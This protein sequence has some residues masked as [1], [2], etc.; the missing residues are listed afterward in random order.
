MLRTG[1]SAEYLGHIEGRNTMGLTAFLI[2]CYQN[3]VECMKLLADAGCNTAAIDN[4]GTNALMRAAC[5][6]AAAAVRTVLDA[7]WCE[8]EAK[9]TDGRTAFLTACCKGNVECM[10]LLAEA[11]CNTAAI[12]IIGNAAA[13]IARGRDNTA[14]VYWLRELKTKQQAAALQ[15]QA[16]DYMSHGRLPEAK[17]A[18]EKALRLMPENYELARLSDVVQSALIQEIEVK[19]HRA[20]VAEAELMAMLDGKSAPMTTEQAQKAQR[21]KEKRRRQKQAK[22][23]AAALNLQAIPKPEQENATE[24]VPEPEPE[25]DHQSVSPARAL[26]SQCS[27]I[28]EDD[29]DLGKGSSETRILPD[30]FCCPITS[31]C[32]RDPVLVT[33]TGMTYEREAITQWLSDHDI[34]PSTGTEL[35]GN[36]VLAPNVILRKLIDAWSRGCCTISL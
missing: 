28:V 14:A 26:T 35:N 12:D 1:S 11:G 30:E 31:E 16:Q 33:A 36:K 4:N 7:G 24:Q 22:R 20:R 27:E 9:N 34:D 13:D 19:E 2:A 15:R 23:E 29:S 17:T 21:K 3:H 8:L 10:K 6:G 18:A 5:S 25:L 32:M